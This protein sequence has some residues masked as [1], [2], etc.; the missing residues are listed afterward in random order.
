MTEDKV[1]LELL[2]RPRLAN[3]FARLVWRVCAFALFRFTP[4]AMH[5]WRRQVLR[6]FGA[7]IG[8][9]VVIYSSA[10]IWAPWNLNLEDGATVGWDCDLYNVA[11]V[12]VGRKGIVSQG[13]HLCTATHDF[14]GKFNLM[15][16]PIDIGA[17]A[18][19]AADAFVGP[20]VQVGNGAVVGARAVAVR[21]VPAWTI[22]AG[23]PAQPLGHR[24]R[25]ATNSLHAD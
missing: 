21:S 14:Q 5:G 4:T 2:P 20:G 12:R 19:V 15:V 25:S 11:L 7:K 17:E 24:S 16:A 8:S 6:L 22:A 10:R 18:W 3:K 23:N 13:A 1:P 9:G